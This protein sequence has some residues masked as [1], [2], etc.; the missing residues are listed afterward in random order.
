MMVRKSA[1]R[2]GGKA[3]TA[4]KHSKG[5]ERELSI[6]SEELSKGVGKSVL[7]E[8]DM[9]AREFKVYLKKPSAGGSRGIYRKF[10][11]ECSKCESEFRHTLD[12]E[13]ASKDIEC[14]SCG[15]KHSVEVSPALKYYRVRMPHSVRIVS[16]E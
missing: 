13:A 10:V 4:S 2:G 3:K 9:D 1:S 7:V 16:S 8:Q 6:V 12:L 14:P 11:L 5:V 15:A